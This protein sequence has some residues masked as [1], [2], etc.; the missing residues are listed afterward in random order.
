MG[1]PPLEP[2]A[3]TTVKWIQNL[4]P[5]LLQLLRWTLN[6]TRGFALKAGLGLNVSLA[7]T[8][9]PP[10]ASTLDVKPHQRVR[11]NA[12][13][14]GGNANLEES[15]SNSLEVPSLEI[16]IDDNPE[17]E[18]AKS[19]EETNMICFVDPDEQPGLLVTDELDAAIAECKAKVERISKDCRARNRKFRFVFPHLLSLPPTI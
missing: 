17:G 7:I 19:T 9:S 1:E 14:P 3:T 10:T 2:T 6:R 18:D 4:P 16:P 11:T 12:K 8:I 15:S 5:P 13:S